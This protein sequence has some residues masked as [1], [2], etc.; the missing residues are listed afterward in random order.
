MTR[1]PQHARRSVASGPRGLLLALAAL[2]A[3][4][5]PDVA[6][7]LPLFARTESAPCARCHLAGPVLNAA[8]ERF[9][10]NGYRATAVA[11][12]RADGAQPLPVSIVLEAGAMYARGDTVGAGGAS[13]PHTTG[14]FRQ[15]ALYLHA[16]GTAG[17]NVSFRIQAGLDSAMSA[18]HTTSAF[19]QFDDVVR[20]GALAIKVGVFDAGLPFLSAARRSTRREYLAPV[21]LAAQGVELNGAH[22]A[23]GYAI[24]QMN[25]SRAGVGSNGH[26][27]NRLEDTYLRVTRTLGGQVVGGRLLFDR[28]DSDIAFHAWL[29]HLQAQVAGRFG[30]DRLW[31]VPAYTLDRFDDRPA[32]GNHQRHQYVLLE[33]LALLGARRDWSLAARLEHEHTTAVGPAPREDRDLAALRLER[34]VTPDARVALEW[35]RVAVTAGVPRESRVDALVQLAY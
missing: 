13:G 24:G 9:M 5:L 17:V 12:H 4:A 10:A 30:T 11:A 15:H 16:A 21:E 2:V 26:G 28:Q 23:W 7:A 25:S 19:V 6:C 31:V 29:Q 22:S 8:G 27:F 34:V 1:S 14:A 32:A 35:S 3:S 18:V 33:A 20:D